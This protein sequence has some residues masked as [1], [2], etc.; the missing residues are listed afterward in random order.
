T[1]N[2]AKDTAASMGL[3]L[4]DLFNLTVTD[5]GPGGSSETYLNLTVKQSSRRV[6]KVLANESSLIAWAGDDL[7]KQ[8]PV[9]PDF[10]KVEGDTVGQAAADLADARKNNPDPTSKAVVDAVKAL[11]DAVVAALASVTDGGALTL[12]DFLPANGETDKK[13]LFA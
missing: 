12:G 10:S 1:G 3:Q 6:D 8:T 11:N 2:G 9:L 13:G 7:G 4:A 5:T